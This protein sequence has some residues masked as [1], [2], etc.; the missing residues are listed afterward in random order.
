M[1]HQNSNDRFSFGK[2]FKRLLGTKTQTYEVPENIDALVEK[3]YTE[4]DNIIRYHA[5]ELVGSGQ[6]V[7]RYIDIRIADDML[8]VAIANTSFEK[9]IYV[10]DE[11]GK[12]SY[13]PTENPQKRFAI[14]TTKNLVLCDEKRQEYLQKLWLKLQIAD[15]TVCA[16]FRQ[17]KDSNLLFSFTDLGQMEDHHPDMMLFTDF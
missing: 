7:A 15:F 2:F 10:Q 13:P 12:F 9:P 11:S 6:L 3:A 14:T 4:I 8:E 16:P 1:L 17:M 5:F